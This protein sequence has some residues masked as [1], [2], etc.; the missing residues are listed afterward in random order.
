MLCLTRYRDAEVKSC[1]LTV[2]RQ[3]GTNDHRYGG[4]MGKTLVMVEHYIAWEPRG[5]AA[6]FLGE[7]EGFIEDFEARLKGWI[8][9]WE[10]GKATWSTGQT[11]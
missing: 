8:E 7:S 2:Q 9:V 3:K 11:A 1:V 4:L 5:R 10:F 6:L